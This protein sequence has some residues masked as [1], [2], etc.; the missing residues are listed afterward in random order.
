[1]A[2][3][4]YQTLIVMQIIWILR[5]VISERFYQYRD[6]RDQNRYLKTENKNE[7][8][9]EVQ[10]EIQLEKYGY[11]RCKVGRRRRSA[12]NLTDHH[13]F[14]VA[15]GNGRSCSDDE[16]KS[17]IKEYQ[18]KYK[19]PETGVVDETT[20]KFMS[21]SR[22]GNSDSDN[23]PDLEP[24]DFQTNLEKMVEN[25]NKF[26][27]GV[28]TKRRWKRSAH[29]TV[30]LKL[31]VGDSSKKHS[32]RRRH[33]FLINHINKLK[34]E[35]P[36]W[37]QPERHKRSINIHIN[38]T[39]ANGGKIRDG[40]KFTKHDIR[41]RLLKTGI[42]TRIPVEEQ[43]ASLNMAF[44]MWSE[45][46]PLK[47]E[48]DLSGDIKAVDIEVAFGRGSHQNCE[49]KFDG[50]GG[51]IAHSRENGKDVVHFDD[52]EDYK[53]IETITSENDGIYLLRVAVHEI[54]HVL[55][56]AHSSQTSSIMYAIYH[57]SSIDPN[58]EFELSWDDRKAV[59]KDYGV[60]KGRFNTVFDW[61]RKTPSNQLIYNTYFFR[62][63]QYW[64]YE[65]H[66]NRTRYGDPLYIALEWKGVPDNIDGYLHIWYFA[67]TK[68][69]DE[70]FFLK[71]DQYY[72]YNSE[73]DKVYD[74]GTGKISEK[75]GPKKGGEQSVP[76][77]LDTV[78]FDM[79]DRNIYFFKGDMV[80]VYDPTD[81]DDETKGCCVRIQ[82]IWEE[83]PALEGEKPIEGDLD[84]VYYSYNDTTVY[85]FKGEDVWKNELFHPRQK[86]IRNGIKYV[87]K[88]YD[89]WY[90]I[91]EV[92][93]TFSQFELPSYSNV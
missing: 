26:Q 48:E 17:A 85:F 51:E 62:N 59:Q 41:W 47:F 86:Q 28:T 20:R 40:Q 4:L 78:Y 24:V 89:H 45:V 3:V 46:I 91:C 69:T 56:L 6:H 29:N 54:G 27:S 61:V 84:A 76:D 14:N 82:K 34:Q 74:G 65:N 81:E 37:L 38:E 13:T 8:H 32:A 66:A 50:H 10:A 52:E 30:L 68:I 57:Q 43:R 31:L 77:N 53:S 35:D 70:T 80:Y 11:L 58:K 25:S 39:G 71:G 18:K 79:R 87:G 21:T 2:R 73:E 7:V 15:E 93:P 42:S 22:C 64:M 16:I 67:G 44:R 1:M 49:R 19:L 36:L 63:N 72:Q 9:D 33:N 12:E 90:D 55:G 75:F 88:W 5:P 92:R 60:C 83:F 23:N